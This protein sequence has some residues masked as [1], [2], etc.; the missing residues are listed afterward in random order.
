[1]LKK[2]HQ[3]FPIYAIK[4]STSQS[5]NISLKPAHIHNLVFYFIHK[6]TDSYDAHRCTN[7]SKYKKKASA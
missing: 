7:T 3:S 5:T 2:S 1:M 6:K 4:S